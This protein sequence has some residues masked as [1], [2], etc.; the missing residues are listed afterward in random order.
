[1]IKMA[2]MGFSYAQIHVR[3]E[4]CRMKAEENQKTA[5]AEAVGKAEEDN[6]RLTA[7]DKKATAGGSWASGRV[8]PCAGTA[9]PPPSNSGQ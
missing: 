2:S 8:H 5:M 3:Q 6:Q 1:M 9:A 7:E 4:R